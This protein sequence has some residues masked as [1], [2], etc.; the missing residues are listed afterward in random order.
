MSK[1]V[2]GLIEQELQKRFTGVSD[3]MVVSLRGIGGNDNNAMRG[4][5]REKDISLTMVK[6]SLARKA[7]AS[8]GMKCMQDLLVGPCAIAYGADSIVD[9]A[10]EMAEW[11]KKI[12]TFEVKGACVEGQILDSAQ[13]KQLATMPNRIE[14]QGTVVMLACAT[15]SRVAGSI[16]G[17]GSYLAGCIKSLVAKLEESGDAQ[18]A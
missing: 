8:Q 4:D 11:G 16:G 17:A 9:V 5:L 2:K 6:N 10:K 14:L 12:E 3:C 13:A 1:K 7:F 18:A 15:G